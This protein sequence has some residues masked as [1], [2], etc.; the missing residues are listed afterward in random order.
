MAEVQV[1]AHDTGA[2][3][4]PPSTNTA[5]QLASSL[6]DLNPKI[7]GL[8]DQIAQKGQ[9]DAA[10]KAKADALSTSGAQFGDAVREGKIL[11]TQNPWYIQAYNRE[12]SVLSSQS[13]LDKLA[14]DSA[15]WP[16]QNDPQQF[17]QRWRTEV[18]K[19]A[20]PY[21]Q[22]PDLMA[23]FS[24]A[25]SQVT[26]QTLSAN[27]AQN[28]HRIT[29]ERTNNISALTS[30][31]LLDASRANAGDVT[32]TI[33]AQAMEPA[34]L[35]FIATGGAEAD[36]KKIVIAS[37]T[38]AAYNSKNSSMLD[39]LKD[40]A[41]V[42]GP[43]LQTV[44]VPDAT[45]TTPPPQQSEAPQQFGEAD[46]TSA[47]KAL[48]PGAVIT[49]TVRSQA[50]NKR[51]GGAAHSMHL[52]GQA[53]DFVV[54]GYTPQQVR[55]VLQGHG[56]PITEFLHETAQDKHSTGDHIHWGW[57]GAAPGGVTGQS[58]VPSVPASHKVI[59]A[60]G[61]S[62]YDQAG[63]A[64]NVEHDRYVIDANS[65]E[66]QLNAI[67]L[68]KAA[69]DQK[70]QAGADFL[71]GKYG[72]RIL[73]GDYDTNGLI[74]DLQN[75]GYSSSDI[76][77]TFNVIHSYTTDS[78]G[79]MN[80]RLNINGADPGKAKGVFD[81]SS[82][83]KL[84]GWSPDYENRVGQ[85]VLAG[86]IKADDGDKMVADALAKSKADEKDSPGAT[87][88]NFAGLGQHAS[89]LAAAV[90]HALKQ[91][92]GTSTDY[93]DQLE[94]KRDI[95]NA[96][97]SWLERHPGD[98]QGAYQYGAQQT[99]VMLNNARLAHLKRSKAPI[100]TGQPDTAQAQSTAGVSDSNP[101]RAQ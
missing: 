95:S 17:A 32:G 57:S 93:P 75:N 64:D 52:T 40:P 7:N 92:Y 24:A 3:L 37:V 87:V 8:L 84:K 48:F 46:A 14:T 73:Q 99:A 21:G 43:P 79:V 22:D 72:T 36:W 61:P 16:E 56:Y 26:Q 62:L 81:L 9:E 25:E 65:V 31:A 20:Q 91:N 86:R 51:V 53:V 89:S 10:A 68:Q 94:I 88:K 15:T 55:A 4:S 66:T 85:A 44:D 100:L 39:L 27:Q 98:F 67:K 69:R 13:A 49:S 80:A 12:S 76:A 11:P 45:G 41:L 74:Q 83:G 60:S 23:G 54:P 82:E 50:D 38:S 18:G 97:G 58:V 19:L 59:L 90:V 63:V 78:E 5:L 1:L 70:G 28:V 29:E 6:A 101:R 2:R 47:I 30:E 71:M 33:A 34:H 35:R 42:G 77:S 96:M